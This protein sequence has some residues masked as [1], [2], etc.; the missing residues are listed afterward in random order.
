MEK[1]EGFYIAM[2]FMLSTMF[3]F[4]DTIPDVKSIEIALVK[5]GYENITIFTRSDTLFVGAENR[6]YRWYPKAYAE[7]IEI[8]MP[9]TV[10][11]TTVCL[12][13]LCRGIPMVMLTLPELAWE[14]GINGI[15]NREAFSS[16]LQT[17]LGISSG[18]RKEFRQTGAN[19]YF[20]KIDLVVYPQVKIQLGNWDDPFKSQFNLAPAFEISFLRGMNMMAQ[21]IIPLQND[22]EPNGSSI[23]P[24]LITIS[25]TMRFPQNFFGVVSVGYFTRNRYGINAEVR[26]FFLNGKINLGLIGGL[27]GYA[28]LIDKQWTY[29]S[30]NLFT[31]FADAAY[32]WV[33]YDLTLKA[34]YGNFLNG[35]AG[36]RVDAYRQFNEVTVG[37]FALET[38]GFLN[39][40]FFF[41]IP[42]PPR[43]YST[44]HAIRIRPESYFSW[45]Y[46]A[47]GMSEAGRSYSTGNSLSDLFHNI[48]PD[49]LKQNVI[50]S[51]YLHF[52]NIEKK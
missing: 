44:K 28:E 27:T 41:S 3:C 43:R 13:I 21:V 30:V 18:Q 51:L 7:M 26:K 34:G 15:L 32:R 49:Y 8:V 46:R 10:R 33:R 6:L 23:R 35:A 38:D 14:D 29:S 12:I 40:G 45:E 17:S 31:W 2:L 48:N 16:F 19:S 11:K 1:T 47:R 20:N 42:L 52:Q 50:N 22:L 24:G 5:K 4:G 37:F 25:Q 39:G 9:F 36:W